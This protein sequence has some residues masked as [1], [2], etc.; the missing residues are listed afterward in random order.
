MLFYDTDVKVVMHD[1]TFRNF[2]SPRYFAFHS[3]THSDVFVY[4]SFIIYFYTMYL[5]IYHNSR[6]MHALRS[7]LCEISDFSFI[8][9]HFLNSSN[10]SL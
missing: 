5:Y 7:N 3:M 8:S 10:E 6:E 9:L 2:N 4:R 1:V